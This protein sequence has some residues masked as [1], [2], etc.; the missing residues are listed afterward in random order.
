MPCVGP[1]I[2]GK[3]STLARCDEIDGEDQT[4]DV[5]H[6]VAI[7][8]ISGQNLHDT[9]GYGHAGMI[10]KRVDLE[11]I[12]VVLPVAGNA[13]NRIVAKGERAGPDDLNRRAAD[14]ELIG[15]TGAVEA[16]IV[17]AGAAVRRDQAIG[18]V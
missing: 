18:Q 4:A 1:F 2:S 8:A 14:L 5:K 13:L 12:G 3:S 11:D 10:H 6:I 7:V 15:A 17:E 9:A 16:Q